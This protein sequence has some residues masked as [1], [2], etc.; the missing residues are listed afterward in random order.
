VCVCVC[1]PCIMFGCVRR[2]GRHADMHDVCVR[3]VTVSFLSFPPT[4]LRTSWWDM[5]GHLHIHSHTHITYT[6]I[7]IY[8][9]THIYIY[10]LYV[11]GRTLSD[12][13]AVIGEEDGHLQ[14][15]VLRVLVPHVVSQGRH[16][17][18]GLGFGVCVR[19]CVCGWVRGWF[20]YYMLVGFVVD[21]LIGGG[22]FILLQTLVVDLCG[23]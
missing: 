21:G 7:Y 12:L 22:S 2:G 10:I 23:W 1:V 13:G 19:V 20:I 16:E 8:K 6:H 17:A 18:K 14:E 3:A 9:H 11:R 4:Y 15:H 5:H